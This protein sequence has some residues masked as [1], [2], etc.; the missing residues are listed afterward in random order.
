MKNYIVVSGVI[1][2][3]VTTTS[4]NSFCTFRLKQK[5]PQNLSISCISWNPKIIEK[6][7]DFEIKKGS[8]VE[9]IGSLKS[10]NYICDK[11]VKYDYEIVV[12]KILTINDKFN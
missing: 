12:S 1:T 8:I 6:I 3:K 10:N 5:A 2:S 11:N 7:N 9:I 4:N